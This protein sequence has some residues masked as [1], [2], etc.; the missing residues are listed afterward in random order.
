MLFR[1]AVGIESGFL[2]TLH[3]WLAYQNLLDGPSISW[4]LPGTIYSHYAIGR[5]SP[6]SLIPKPTSAIEATQR[7]L[8]GLHG[9]LQCMSFRIPTQTV[10]AAN[11]YLTLHRD[12]SLEEIQSIFDAFEASQRWSIIHNNREPLVSIDFAQTE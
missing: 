1:S 2:T 7:V 12:A 9:A 8:P 5:A 4:A 6:G 10:G 11:L 3:P